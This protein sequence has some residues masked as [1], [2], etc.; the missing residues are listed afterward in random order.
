MVLTMNIVLNEI[1]K[2]ERDQMVLMMS[3]V[4]NEITKT[5]RDQM[6]EMMNNVLNENMETEREIMGDVKD[7]LAAIQMPSVFEDKSVI[8]TML[9]TLLLLQK[10]WKVV[11]SWM[12]LNIP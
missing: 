7:H 10:V 2:T 5:E 8:Q 6:V 4:L 11:L 1:T 12:V 3:S 9:S